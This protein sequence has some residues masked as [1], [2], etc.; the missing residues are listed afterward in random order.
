LSNDESNT[1]KYE[2]EISSLNQN[3]ANSLSSVS[4]DQVTET[5]IGLIDFI[6]ADKLIALI[7]NKHDKGTTFD[8]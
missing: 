4:S 6:D 1:K 5:S 7:I 2:N 3:Y 8:H